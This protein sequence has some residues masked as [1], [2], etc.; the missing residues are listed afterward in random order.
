MIF[1]VIFNI[2]RKRVK[3]RACLYFAI[4]ILCNIFYAAYA[5]HTY[6]CVAYILHTYLHNLCCILCCIL[7]ATV[8]HF[9]LHLY[10][11]RVWLNFI[12]S[13]GFRGS[14]S[15]MFY[16]IAVLNNFAKLTGKHLWWS[17]F[18]IKSN[19]WFPMIFVEFSRTPIF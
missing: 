10:I 8:R 19:T 3:D 15:Q 2:L 11:A 18:S 14:R 17:H 13:K 16:K 6:L 1:Y 9:L 5:L 7:W 12:T 4:I